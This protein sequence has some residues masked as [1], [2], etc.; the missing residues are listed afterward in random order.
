MTRNEQRC[1]HWLRHALR[2]ELGIPCDRPGRPRKLKDAEARAIAIIVAAQP[3]GER[4]RMVWLIG[5]KLQ[6]SRATLH[7]AISCHMPK[8]KVRSMT[9]SLPDLSKPRPSSTS[10]A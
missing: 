8:V 5:E 6:I 4:D 10:A 3:R 7:R 2:D 1:Y 9:L